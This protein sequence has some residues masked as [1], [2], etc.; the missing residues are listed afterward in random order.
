MPRRCTRCPLSWYTAL[1]EPGEKPGQT[2]FALPQYETV[3]LVE[4]AVRTVVFTP[5]EAAAWLRQVDGDA[6]S[7]V[8]TVDMVLAS[9]RECLDCRVA[10]WG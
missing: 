5:E 2:A 10:W 4:P 6:T 9:L 1:P 7:E 3:R 8:V